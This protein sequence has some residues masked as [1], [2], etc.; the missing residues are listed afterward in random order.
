MRKAIFSI[1][2]A[3]G[4]MM[5]APA[6]LAEQ[7]GTSDVVAIDADRLATAEKTIDHIF[8]NG[9]YSR[10]MAA[11]MDSTMDIV[12]DSIG[13][14]PLRD[15]AAIGGLSKS[16]LEKL[17]PG[18]ITEIM[19][20][21]DPHYQERMERMMKSMSTE[22]SQLIAM[23][24]PGMRKGLQRAYAKRFTVQQLEEM[25]MFFSTPTGKAYA[26]E[27]LMMFVDPE[28]VSQMQAFMPE[29]MKQMPDIVAKLKKT[30]SDLPPSRKFRDLNKEERKKLADLL[31]ISEDELGKKKH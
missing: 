4:L 6:A 23:F 12:M 26:A 29:M 14:I 17:G 30:T 11:T 2:S 22:M 31:G 7:P 25:N 18:T 8:P 28:V 19:A 20:I 1:A 5:M 16:K 27:S 24:E 13:N 21:Y 15:L 10:M 9:T 3:I